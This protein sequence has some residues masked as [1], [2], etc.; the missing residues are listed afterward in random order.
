MVDTARAE[1][2]DLHIGFDFPDAAAG[3]HVRNGVSVAT[4]GVGAAT[5]LAV[6]WADLVRALS[7]EVRLS[8]LEASGAL[9][10]TGD[11]VRARRALAVFDLPGFR[12]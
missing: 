10:I 3:L 7:D 5:R 9:A 4:G 2:I 8:D 6:R 11:A 12:G 1:G